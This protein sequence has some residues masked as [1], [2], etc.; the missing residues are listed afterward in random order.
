M[1]LSHKNRFI[2]IKTRKT[3]GTSIEAYLR[4]FL[5]ENDIATPFG[6]FKG[7]N[8]QSIY[9]PFIDSAFW[10]RYFTISKRPI[11]LK[12]VIKAWGGAVQ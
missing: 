9:N 4:N 10:F 12:R 11:Y 6:K 2:F 8:L 5:G 7:Q 1:I 3:A